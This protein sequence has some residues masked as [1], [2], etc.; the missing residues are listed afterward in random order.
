MDAVIFLLLVLAGIVLWKRNSP[1]TKGFFGERKVQTALN[2]FLDNEK[3]RRI[4]NVILPIHGGTTQIDHV[5]VS[6]YGVFVVETKN[7]KGWIFGSEEQREW[8]QT[9]YRKSYKFQN[10]LRQNYLHV[11]ALED[12]LRIPATCI[13]SVVVFSGNAKFKT[14]IPSNVTDIAGLIRYIRSFDRP[15][16]AAEVCESIFSRIEAGQLSP[17][18]KTRKRHVR[19]LKKRISATSEGI[20]PRCGGNLVVRSLS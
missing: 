18:A 12:L 16:F 17:T 2:R 19:D 3:Y 13:H 9:L 6:M 10:P 1:S 8:T 7:M 4:D 14:E 11:K 20:C 15:V 5:I